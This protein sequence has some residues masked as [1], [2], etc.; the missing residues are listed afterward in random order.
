MIRRWLCGLLLLG[1]FSAQSAP[2]APED[3]AG[4][5]WMVVFNNPAA[6]RD[7]EYN[8]W[9]QHVHAPDVVAFKDVIS[10]QRFAKVEIAGGVPQH[11]PRDYMIVYEIRSSDIAGTYAGFKA[12]APA[13]TPLPVDENSSYAVT[14]QSLGAEIRGSEPLRARGG[15]LQT[16]YFMVLDEPKE[17]A[18]AAFNAWYEDAHLRDMLGT[19]G[20]V[21]AR[22][23]QRSTVQRSKTAA[24]PGYLAVYRIVTDDIGQAFAGVRQRA[25][26]FVKTDSVN[27]ATAAHFTYVARGPLITRK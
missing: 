25:G 22:R 14:F 27:A 8:D 4:N 20:W 7:A 21:G 16:Y 13:A 9:Y 23:F 6:G 2:A 18:D 1:A 24:V 10:A 19:P 12:P 3:T 26:G 11:P 5:Y 17:G 15:E